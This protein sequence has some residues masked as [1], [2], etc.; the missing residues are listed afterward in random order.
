MR[1]V[2]ECFLLTEARLTD[3]PLDRNS[4]GFISQPIHRVTK[5]SV[6]RRALK[7]HNKDVKPQTDGITLKQ[8]SQ[9]EV[10]KF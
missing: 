7:L 9:E 6:I 1:H 5:Q 4:S 2:D 10:M 8:E 3:G